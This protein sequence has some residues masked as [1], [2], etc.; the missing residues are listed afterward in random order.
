MRLPL[1]VFLALPLLS[2]VL[3]AAEL[4]L[5]VVEKVEAQQ[6]LVR[7]DANVHLLP[8]SMLALYGAGRVEKHPLTKEVIIEARKLQAKAQILAVEDARRQREGDL[9][10]A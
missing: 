5:G 3:T 2:A 4:P 1:F 7:F 8:G 9:A 10:L 6:V